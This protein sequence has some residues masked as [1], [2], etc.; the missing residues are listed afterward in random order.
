MNKFRKYVPFMILIM[1]F[2]FNACSEEE[3]LS[4]KDNSPKTLTLSTG[5]LHNQGLEYIYKESLLN[6]FYANE[7]ELNNQVIADGT[8]FVSS[9]YP[10]EQ[11]TNL[12]TSH[13]YG[14]NDNILS[15]ELQMEIDILI[16]YLDETITEE[17]ENAGAQIFAYSQNILDN[18]PI[19]LSEV[20]K[21]AWKN[22]VDVMGYSALYWHENMSKWETEVNRQKGWLGRLWK[23]IKPVVVADLVGAAT[24][25]V[26]GWIKGGTWVTAGAGALEGGL[27]SSA[28]AGIKE[29]F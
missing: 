25:F 9:I 17:N 16:A 5:K 27:G 21:E 20:D 4:I 15:T 6:Q 7:T 28:G 26:K 18:P 13:Y 12:F 14:N 19:N 29:L 2:T 22:A 24:G 8:D 11:D 23:K 10:N 1:A 3:D